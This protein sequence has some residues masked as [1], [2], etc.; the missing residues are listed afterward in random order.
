MRLQLLSS[1]AI[2]PANVRMG[3]TRALAGSIV[4]NE[5]PREGTLSHTSVSVDPVP[6][7]LPGLK[8]LA[9]SRHARG[10]IALRQRSSRRPVLGA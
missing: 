1:T 9:S 6:R 10:L 3:H 8:L 4:K 7:N 5:V 2:T